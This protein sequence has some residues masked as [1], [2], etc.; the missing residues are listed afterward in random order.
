MEPSFKKDGSVV[1][2]R[3]KIEYIIIGFQMTP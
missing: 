3:E 2:I 1:M